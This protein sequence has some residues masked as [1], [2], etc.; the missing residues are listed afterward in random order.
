MR[1]AEKLDC[2]VLLQQKGQI[3]VHITDIVV[4]KVEKMKLEITV[5]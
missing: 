3:H 2:K 1:L 4:D 5:E